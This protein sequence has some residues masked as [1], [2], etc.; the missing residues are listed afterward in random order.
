MDKAKRYSDEDLE[1]FR[2]LILKKLMLAKRNYNL[3]KSA[4]MDCDEYDS[5]DSSPVYKTLEEGGTSL[6]REETSR[7]ANR[8][9]QFIQNLN[10]ALKRIDNKTYG[11]CRITGQL[12]SKERL[13]AVPHATLSIE[14]KKQRI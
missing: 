8:Q 12:I 6:S 2:V 3:L 13:R 10:S 14:A 1:E 5:A 11:I 7:L 9:L 4:V